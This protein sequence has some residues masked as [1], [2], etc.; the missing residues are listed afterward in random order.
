MIALI[1]GYGSAGKRH[2]KVLKKISYIKKIYIV[3]SQDKISTD[4]VFF[5]K[6][7]KEINPKIIV[8]ANET[9]KHKDTLVDLEKKFK[10]KIIIVEKPLFHKFYNLKCTNNKVFVAY[11]L[12]FHHILKFI[13]KNILSGKDKVFYV[14][15]ETSS[16]LPYWRKNQDYSKSY[17][18][19]KKKG[20]GTLL[21]LSHEIDYIKWLFKDFKIKKIF[22]NK[23]SSLNITSNDFTLILGKLQNRGL[24]KLKM[25]YFNKLP[26]RILII[27]FE[28]GKQIYADLLK[29]NLKIFYK[30]NVK[31][32]HFKKSSSYLMTKEMY[33]DIFKNKYTNICT[34]KEALN[35][36]KSIKNKFFLI[37]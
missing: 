28:N 15:A 32:V 13:K 11:N 1:I 5:I 26:K 6:K 23:I 34:Y 12:R 18:S 33:L 21:D 30:E 25:T 20:G 8:I 17:S 29:S 22:S 19:N 14:E 3:T 37:N 7:I 9:N 4:K 2:L 16:Y 10:N 36:L 31:S 27:C 35:L 24:I